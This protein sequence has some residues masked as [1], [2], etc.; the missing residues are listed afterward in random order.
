MEHK[1]IKNYIAQLKA[2]KLERKLK[3][4]MSKFTIRKKT[5]APIEAN[6]SFKQDSNASSDDDFEF[7][8]SFAEKG[9]S[10]LDQTTDD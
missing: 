2:T 9:S 3:L 4:P 1:K 8:D 5:D 7:L 6:N 10:Y